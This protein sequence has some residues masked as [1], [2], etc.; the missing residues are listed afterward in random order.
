MSAPTYRSGVVSS[1]IETVAES[2]LRESGITTPTQSEMDEVRLLAETIVRETVDKLA[3]PR[4]SLA[5]RNLVDVTDLVASDP[6]TASVDQIR[7]VA[8]ALRGLL[9]LRESMIGGDR[10]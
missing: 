8:I 5:Q 6:E 7:E 2:L 4:D 3:G 1:M 9:D 10:A